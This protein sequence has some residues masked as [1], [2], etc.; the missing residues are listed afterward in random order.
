MEFGL[1]EISS[2]ELDSELRAFIGSAQFPCVGAKS[3]CA[4]GG[5]RVIAAR[6]ISSGW[7]DLEIYRELAAWVEL[8]AAQRMGL[9]SLAVIFRE[10]RHLSELQFEQAMWERLQSLADKDAS[11]GGEYDYSVSPR[12]DDA[13]FAV[14]FAGKAFFIVGLH[15]GATRP[16]RRFAY[17]TMIFNLHAQFVRLRELQLYE[18]MRAQIIKRDIALAGS[19]NPM[20]AGHG[21]RS[22]ARQYSGRAVSETWVCPFR[23]P[24]K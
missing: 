5:L 17:P 3:A 4:T 21:E 23:D 18:P 2:A 20:L 24:R 12:P 13:D 6:D 19:A 10:A 7:N 16:A 22:A 8:H 14:S 15:P 1:Q 11:H 9:C